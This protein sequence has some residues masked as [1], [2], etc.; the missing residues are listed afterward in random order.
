MSAWGESDTKLMGVEATF[1]GAEGVDVK[2]QAAP[3]ARLSGVSQNLFEAG[4]TVGL[5]SL[6]YKPSNMDAVATVITK[7]WPPGLLS[8]RGRTTG[9]RELLGGMM[10]AGVRALT[11]DG[12]LRY[13]SYV[14]KEDLWI[15]FFQ[16]VSMK[17]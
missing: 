4:T 16:P 15:V 9:K 2:A 10:T 13:L 3:N 5:R 1:A 8:S 11:S 12:C 14:S 7:S 17:R 6:A